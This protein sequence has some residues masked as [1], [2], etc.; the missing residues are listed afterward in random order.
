MSHDFGE[1][2][3]DS[4]LPLYTHPRLLLLLADKGLEKSQPTG[5][6]PTAP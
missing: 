6:I 1:G 4:Y 5:P 3:K 2:H